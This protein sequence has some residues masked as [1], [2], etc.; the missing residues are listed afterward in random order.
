MLV[1]A[2][3][4]KALMPRGGNVP[5]LEC[6]QMPCCGVCTQCINTSFFSFQCEDRRATTLFV[7]LYVGR[8]PREPNLCTEGGA[9][10][11]TSGYRV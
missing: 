4:L 9:S 8:H 5:P 3:A 10:R 11:E 1:C 2:D 6:A 7:C